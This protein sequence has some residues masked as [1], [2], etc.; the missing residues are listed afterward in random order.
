MSRLDQFDVAVIGAGVVG[1]A[2]ALLLSQAGYR[3]ALVEPQ[4]DRSWSGVGSDLRVYALAPDA[5]VLLER[6]GVW[7][8]IVEHAVVYRSM[9][10]WDAGGEQALHL[11]ANELARL[12]LGWIVEHGLMV[13]RLLAACSGQKNITMFCPAMLDQLDVDEQSVRLTLADGRRIGCA[14]VLGAD[15]GQSKLRQLG[16]IEVDEYDYAQLGLVAYI[17]TEQPHQNTAWQRFLPGGPLAVLPYHQ[18][19]CSI[20]WTQ[21]DTEARR[22][23]QMN[24]DQ[25]C[26]EL[27]RA[28]DRKLGRFSLQSKRVLFPLKRK[29]STTMARERIALLGDAAHVV[30]PLAG[31]GVNLGLRDVAGLSTLIHQ[32]EAKPVLWQPDELR[33]WGITRR[34]EAVIAAHTFEQIN[35]LYSNDAFIPGL[36]RSKILGYTDQLTPIKQRL[37]KLAI[38]T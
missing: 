26:L 3:V 2:A 32:R 24:E 16:A 19:L 31:Q 33:R 12:N 35:R 10:V 23:T 18:G 15:G 21:P 25:F 7:E 13:D 38:G 1:S 17:Q 37:M 9:H 29:L 5:A 27:E 28:F 30:H 36:L 22:R 6:L 34:S 20:V 8:R 4:A 11:D 14:Y